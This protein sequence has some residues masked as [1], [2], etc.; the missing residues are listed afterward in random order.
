MLNALHPVVNSICIAAG[1]T[2]IGVFSTLVFLEK[3]VSVGGIS[4]K[5]LSIRHAV[6][7]I[8]EPIF[9]GGHTHSWRKSSYRH[10]CGR[11]IT[12]TRTARSQIRASQDSY[13]T[14][15]GGQQLNFDGIH[16]S[17]KQLDASFYQRPSIA[18][19]RDKAL[20]FLLVLSCA[21]SPSIA[22]LHQEHITS[23]VFCRNA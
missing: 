23:H 5:D 20:I 8:S 6:S 7:A 11:R 12:P 13:M 14:S 15:N 1:T 17:D 3:E 4:I 18:S 21:P 16:D 2:A 19:Q 22:K 10:R 9:W